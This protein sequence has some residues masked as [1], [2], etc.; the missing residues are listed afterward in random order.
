MADDA[1]DGKQGGGTPT[2]AGKLVIPDLSPMS[3]V[4]QENVKVVTAITQEMSET[5]QSIVSEQQSVLKK[6]LTG[7]QTSVKE[8][9]GNGG[10]PS[11]NIPDLKVSLDNL[12]MTT[13]SFNSAAEKLT[14]STTKSHD[15]LTESVNKSMAK[16]EEVAKKFSGG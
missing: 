16:I 10:I 8:S 14:K 4:Q 9:S 11:S 15:Q 3:E 1:A 7:L 12:K 2:M 13:D 6:A 5:L